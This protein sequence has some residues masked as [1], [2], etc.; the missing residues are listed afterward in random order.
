MPVKDPGASAALAADSANT[1]GSPVLDE[2]AVVSRSNI[3]QWRRHWNFMWSDRATSYTDA[4]QCLMIAWWV[5]EGMQRK[6][7]EEEQQPPER[8]TCEAADG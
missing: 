5:H 6:E 2:A 1:S 4:G 8:R 7:G 3:S